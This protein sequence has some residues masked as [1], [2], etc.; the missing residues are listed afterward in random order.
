MR[1]PDRTPFRSL[2]RR[3]LTPVAPLA[4]LLAAT[5]AAAACEGPAAV[6]PGSNA[7]AFPLIAS[8][9]PAA[10]FVEAGDWPGVVRAVKDLQSD[11][12][13][14]AGSPA[15]LQDGTK[16][17]AGPVVIVGTLGHSA[18]IEKLAREGR[19]DVS[20]VKGRWEA[21][22]QQVVDH[23]APG[24]ERALVIAG[25]DKRGTIFGVYDLS[26]RM[27]VSP[28]AWWADVPVQ[29][30]ADEYVTAG[31]RVEAPK[32][33]YRGIFLNDEEP[34]LGGWVRATYG[35]F[36]HQFYGRV[37]ELVLRM[38]GDL[39][40]P[41]MWGKAF[42]DDDPENAKLAD[43]YGV[44]MATSHHEPMMRANV[45]WQRYG[46]GGAW[47]YTVNAEALRDFW[48]KGVERMGK[49]E[50]LVTIGMRGD[51][52]KPMTQGTA[53]ALLEQIV[54]DQRKIIG[55]V[56]GK[57]PSQTPQV[58]ALYK[59]VQDY[60]DKGMRVPDDVTL[61][62]SDDNWG[63]LRRLPD[64]KA[65]PRAGGYGIYYHFDYVGGPRNYKWINTNQVERTWEQMHMAWAYG[66][67][68]LWIVNVGDLKPMELPIQFFLDY[69]WDP[70]AMPV[71]R[72]AGYTREW[73]A[74]QFGPE[75]AGEIAELLDDY[76]R[77]NARR[78]PEL[79]GPETFSLLNYR[80]AERVADDWAA[81]AD[82]AR[83]LKA[84]LPAAD[85]A[86][87]EELVAYPVEA[88]ANLN[89][90]YVTTAQN[91][92]WAEQGR[93]A[94]NEAAAEVKAMFARDH[95]LSQRYMA[96][97]NGKWV[98]MMDQTHIGYTNWQQPDADA[99]PAVRTIN[100]PKGATLGV[101]VEGDTRAW[102]QAGG[103]PELP[104]FDRWGASSRYIEVFTRGEGGAS[105][106]IEGAPSWLKVSQAS[107]TM[108]SNA[109][110]M[111][112]QVRVELSVDWAKAPAG[113]S[114][115]PLTVKGTDG[116]AVTV[117]VQANNP[118]AKPAPGAFVDADGYVA[119]EAEHFSRAVSGGGVRWDVVPGLGR[120]LS[121]VTS[122]PVTEGSDQPGGDGL[123]LEYK[124]WLTHAGDVKLDVVTAPSLDVRG[125]GGLRFAVSID[126]QPPVTIDID[127][128]MSP[129]DWDKA[130]ADNGRTLGTTVHVAEP[131]LH[132]VKLWR[133]DPGVVFE[134]I[135]L[136]TGGLK[137]SYLGP[138]ESQKSP[139]M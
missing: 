86:A 31:A 3:L 58:W 130:V 92:L 95:E 16:P 63:D 59:E 114:R 131:G 25:A 20:R 23:P 8:S 94:T 102:P 68:Q 107:A 116:T 74:K 41:A 106:T 105:Y 88:S 100:V 49:D 39:L 7:A 44:V 33:K 18:V 118:A 17:G 78:K 10:V 35:G 119:I 51:G 45:E 121:G 98:H 47:D 125:Q 87:F 91:R 136:D 133:V 111:S 69:A 134:R 38:K 89:R 54:A 29:H 21:F 110:Y 13:Q 1:R 15:V 24:V 112:D 73:A 124:V 11:L 72:M 46:K 97:A 48:R 60:Y 139:P 82:K 123:R 6:C 75:H 4:V 56:T 103:R 138:P 79:L 96:A 42:A 53:I 64:L 83:K 137:P 65:K 34:S 9:K 127:T 120:T 67:K 113:L 122:F 109:G 28:W 80:E 57:D 132:V 19:I 70:D 27:G 126:D 99:M 90:L 135:V 104:T 62:F 84:E 50:S 2:V 71:E 77:F 32:V 61:L 22:V 108:N 43:E 81:L 85:Q 5:A 129:K 115:V 128:S 66:A 26:Q 30:R 101:A 14:V 36:N 76:T 117:V 40:W 37:F 52:D 12:G 55:D 93:A